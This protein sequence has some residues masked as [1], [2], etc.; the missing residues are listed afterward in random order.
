[1]FV[2]TRAEMMRTA[3]PRSMCDTVSKRPSE[4]MPNVKKRSSSYRANIKFSDERSEPAELPC[5]AVVF[6]VHALRAILVLYVSVQ[7]F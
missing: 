5:Y 2:A 4:K 3:F 6:H 7:I 1:M